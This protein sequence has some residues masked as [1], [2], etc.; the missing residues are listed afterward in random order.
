MLTSDRP[1]LYQLTATNAQPERGSDSDPAGKHLP[2]RGT[3]ANDAARYA[4]IPPASTIG[5]VIVLRCDALTIPLRAERPAHPA[6]GKHL[7][8]P[9]GAFARDGALHDH[10]F[11]RSFL[12]L[13]SRVELSTRLL[14]ATR[15]QRG[16]SARE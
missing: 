11:D 2:G 3:G 1:T 14:D 8:Q 6:T 10:R 7:N 13:V 4:T 15:W 9:G 5:S 12:T 16:C